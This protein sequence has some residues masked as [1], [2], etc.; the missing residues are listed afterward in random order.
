MNVASNVSRMLIV[1]CLAGALAG[2]E[3]AEFDVAK[4]SGDVTCGGEPVM[5]G[6]VV[7]TPVGEGGLTGKPATATVQP[8]GTFELSTYETGDGAIVGK[9]TVSFWGPEESSEE[10]DEGSI[11]P[12]SPEGMKRAAERS[13]KAAAFRKLASCG[14]AQELIL[15]VKPGQD[16]RFTIELTP[17]AGETDEAPQNVDI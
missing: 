16:N 4:V 5:M 7:F 8:D 10:E 1:T 11:N 17:G 2:C 3:N 14:L 12:D 15:E 9:H 13:K 6:T